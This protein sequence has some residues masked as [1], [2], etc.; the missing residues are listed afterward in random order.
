MDEPG[1]SG[2]IDLPDG[3]PARPTV[4]AYDTL[5][6]L[7]QVRQGGQLQ[8]DDY[9]GGQTRTFTYTSLAHLVSSTNPESGTFIF[10]YDDAGNLKKKINPRLHPSNPAVHVEATY[11]YDELGRLKSRSYND[12]TATSAGTPDVTYTYDDLSVTNSRGRLTKVAS[13]AS[14][15]RYTAYDSLGRVTNHSQFT[16]GA[17]YP[18]VYK[19]NAAGLVFWETYPSG[20]VVKTDY[21]SAGQVAAVYQRL[22]DSGA[23]NNYATD[24]DYSPAGGVRLFKLGNG[25][26]EHT[27]YNS[28][29]QPVEI[30]LGTSAADSSKLRLEYG[31]GTTNNN[32]NLRSQ[33]I[34]APGLSL[35]QT[36]TYDPLNRLETAVEM[37]GAQESWK[38][39]YTYD[40]FGNRRIDPNP[41]ATSADLV[42]PNPDISPV[43]NRIST[44]GYGYDDAGDLTA[45]PNGSGTDTYV[46]DAEGR[47]GSFNGGP[48][49]NA[50]AGYTYDGDG[51]RVKKQVGAFTTVYVYD[52]GGRLIA[53]Y[54]DEAPELNGTQYLTA[55]HLGSPRVVT[56]SQQQVK[57]RHD[58]HP[59][60]EEVGLRGGRTGAVDPATGGPGQ[61]YLSGTLRQKFTGKE[62]DDETGL[63]YFGA[64]YHAPLHGRFTSPDPLLTSGAPGNPQSWNR[65]AY[66][67]NN[68]LRY[69]DPLGLFIWSDALGGDKSDN[70]LDAE[71]AAITDK[72]KRKKR[73]KEVEEIKKQRKV[74]IDKLKDARDKA[75]NPGLTPSQR[76][77]VNKALAAYGDFKDGKTDNVIVDLTKKAGPMTAFSEDMKNVVVTLNLSQDNRDPLITIAHEGS[78][79]ADHQEYIQHSGEPNARDNYDIP[80]W[81]TEGRAYL[82]S[83]Y[84][85]QLLDKDSYYPGAEKKL[86]VWN[87]GWKKSSNMEMK[88][89]V[90]VHSWVWDNYRSS[91]ISKGITE[92]TKV[93][94]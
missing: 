73:L 69:T 64:R 75:N 77:E 37:N 5:G 70:E 53:E 25:L 32:G 27:N 50:G 60:G 42:G 28:R 26:F 82:V 81:E 88:R 71:A 66:T 31:F 43:T 46:Y 33:K 89:V 68:P 92:F 80:L 35:T 15:T 52:Y 56:D 22:N 4:Y 55:D 12:E 65:Y 39:K 47:I 44:Q 11:D 85:A 76:A 1:A 62:R 87:K 78:H 58:Y 7:T 63:D 74:F 91:G 48:A 30:G 21:S 23:M 8:G 90:G 14:E 49:P 94:L 59:F 93:K 61:Q 36:Y 9:L 40:A 6:N 2:T 19:Y 34:T 10:E 29:L 16:R 51:R 72:K 3:S 67:V 13:A 20:R 86:Q 45:V 79:V 24:F 17:E 83:S 41:A 18:F 54:T 57:A 84:M 38:Q